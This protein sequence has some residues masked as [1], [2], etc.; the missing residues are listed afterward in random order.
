M[1]EVT[2]Q[3]CDDSKNE[4]ELDLRLKLLVIFPFYFILLC[5][6]HCFAIRFVIDVSMNFAS[7]FSNKDDSKC[8][9]I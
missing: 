1:I 4:E 7:L 3:V 8:N 6:F 2:K 5:W 9:Y